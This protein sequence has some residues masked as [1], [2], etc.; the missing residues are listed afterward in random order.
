MA[1]MWFPASVLSKQAAAFA[2]PPTATL[3][4]VTAAINDYWPPRPRAQ[5]L[6]PAR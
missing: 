2:S 3:A 4:K 6:A 5:L 1:R